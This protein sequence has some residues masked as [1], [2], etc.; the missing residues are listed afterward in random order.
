MDGSRD[1]GF[2]GY[3]RTLT[4]VSELSMIIKRLKSQQTCI[5]RHASAAI[6]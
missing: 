5:K 3:T 1:S 6:H 4:L 2:M